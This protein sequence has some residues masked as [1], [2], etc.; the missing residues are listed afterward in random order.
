[1]L[2]SGF[3]GNSFGSS[4]RVFYLKEDGTKNDFWIHPNLRTNTWLIKEK[5]KKMNPNLLT[6][7]FS[8][9]GIE[10]LFVKDEDWFR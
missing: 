6:T 5:L 4:F 1:M 9:G 7:N 2:F 3:G 8:F 10:H